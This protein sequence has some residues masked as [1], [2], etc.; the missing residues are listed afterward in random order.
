MS[1]DPIEEFK[2]QNHSAPAWA[3][4]YGINHGEPYFYTDSP[5]ERP[6]LFYTVLIVFFVL[7]VALI[8]SIVY[9]YRLNGLKFPWFKIKFYE[10]EST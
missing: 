9:V 5:K 8:Y 2:L 10:R 6:V 4:Y 7:Y 3:Q 1:S